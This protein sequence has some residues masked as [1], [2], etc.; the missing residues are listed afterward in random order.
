[1]RTDRPRA[2]SRNW[3]VGDTLSGGIG[4]NGANFQGE[5]C[6]RNGVI[7]AAGECSCGWALTR[8]S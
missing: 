7:F 6:P 1:M 3:H 5:T 4:A 2:G 8:E